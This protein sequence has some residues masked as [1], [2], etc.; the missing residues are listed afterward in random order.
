[1]S[2]PD[3][4]VKGEAARHI[5]GFTRDDVP[6]LEQI[7]DGIHIG[8][9][10]AAGYGRISAGFTRMDA[11]ARAPLAAP[12]EEVWVLT[13]G[14]MR[15]DSADGVVSAR[16]GDLVHLRPA[17]RGELEVTDDLDMLALAF[18]PLWEVEL[19]A[20]ELAREQSVA[21]P[22]ARVLSRDRKAYPQPAADRWLFTTADAGRHFEMGFGRA[23][24]DGAEDEFTVAGDR[25]MVATTGRFRIHT[26][27]AAGPH[28]RVITVE[29]GG[30]AYLPAGTSGT[31]SAEPGSEI[32]WAHLSRS[33]R[34]RPT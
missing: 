18:P 13:A 25:V 5:R 4:S 28:V 26:D 6:A 16:P 1:M 10:L 9:A 32:A 7:A 31:L 3:D 29:Q 34:R 15:I 12:Y 19:E 11:G 22:F 20:W 2:A 17:S 21:G 24:T 27:G 30:F 23:G 8:A 33:P 14:A